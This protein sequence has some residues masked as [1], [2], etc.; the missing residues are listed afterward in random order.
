MIRVLERNFFYRM[1][2]VLKSRLAMKRE[3]RIQKKRKEPYW[4]SVRFFKHLFLLIFVLLLSVPTVLCIYFANSAQKSKQQL[5]MFRVSNTILS[6]AKQNNAIQV[7]SLGQT[8]GLHGITSRQAEVEHPAYQEYY[9]EMY[10]TYPKQFVKTEQKTVYLTFD[11]GPSPITDTVL[12]VLAQKQVKASFFIT[13]M[14]LE[15]EE[16]V[17][18]LKRIAQEGHSIGIHTYSHNYSAIYTSVEAFLDDFYKAW[19]EAKEI[20]GVAPTIF[21][22]PGGS[23]NAYN[24]TLCQ[25]IIAEMVRRG[26]VYFDWNVSAQDAAATHTTLPNI[27][28]NATAT[29]N[30]DRIVLLMHDSDAKQNTAKAL[31]EIIDSYQSSGY[32][33]APLQQDTKP[34]IFAYQ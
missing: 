25:E 32:A 2:M 26:F 6:T 23:I 19:K 34:I 13:G 14:Q 4:G 28:S 12:D 24:G 20:T 9:P 7:N 8:V 3:Q 18:R 33:V 1:A 11:D 17:T 22:F 16:N 30:Y 29:R 5:D 31:P 15:K 10:V 27:V 21:R